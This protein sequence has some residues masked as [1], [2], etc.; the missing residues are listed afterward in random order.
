M[1]Y[2]SRPDVTDVETV[3]MLKKDNQKNISYKIH[4]KKQ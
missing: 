1:F 4:E 2:S 3:L